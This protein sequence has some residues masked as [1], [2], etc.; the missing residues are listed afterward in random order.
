MK[1]T[2]K[3][4]EEMNVEFANEAGI[5]IERF[6]DLTIQAQMKLKKKITNQRLKKQKNES[7]NH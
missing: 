2:T 7:I 1:C 3:S 5:C 4:I 6:N